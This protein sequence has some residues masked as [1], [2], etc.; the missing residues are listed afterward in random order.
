MPMQPLTI[1]ATSLVNALGQGGAAVLQKLLTGQSG[2]MPGHGHYPG[3]EFETYIGQVEQAADYAIEPNLASYNCRNNRL[4]KLGLDS[5]G[6]RDAV[7][8]A[9]QRYGSSRIG[10][11]MGTSTSGIEETEKAYRHCDQHGQLPPGFNVLHTH[12]IA[13]VQAYTQAALGLDG[14]GMTISTACSSSAKVFASAHRHIMA[15]Y[16]DAAV[17]GGVDSLCLTTLY[18]FNSLQLVSAEPCRPWDEQRAGINIGEA[19][20]FALLEKADEQTE[21]SK[22]LGY[23]ES[24]DAYHMSTPHPQGKGAMLAMQQAL[25][26]AGLNTSD[27]DYINLHG[28]ATPS[29]DS[30]EDA[31]VGQLFD[32]ATACSSTKGFTG[33]TLGAAGITEILF[34]AMALQEGFVPANLNLQHQDPVLKTLVSSEVRKQQL[35][36][37]MSNSFG[38]GGSNCSVIIG[39]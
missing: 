10:V 36:Y 2:L 4:A 28:T 25:K 29:N 16:C 34:C 27:I 19:A 17:V 8:N 6:F 15:G 39:R 18:G 14:V 22:L 9:K 3:L 31:A 38:F 13:S 33:H 37:A 5:D 35:N 26:R 12:N 11:F 23:G 20:G 30:A 1:T 24:S 32:T 21:G 7:D